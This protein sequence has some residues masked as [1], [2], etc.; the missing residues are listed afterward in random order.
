MTEYNDEGPGTSTISR[1][2][3]LLTLLADA[4]GP[5]TV[6]QVSTDL[7]VPPSTAHRLLNALAGEGFVAASG[8]GIYRIGPRFYRISARVMQSMSQVTIAQPIIDALAAKYN[9]TV[10]LGRYVAADRAMDFIYRADGSQRLTYQIDLHRP[11]SLYW[12]ASGKA[13]LAFLPEN[14]IEQI[15]RQA[16]ASPASGEKPPS[17]RAGMTELR[18]VRERGYAIT[19]GQKLPGAQ[20]V[21]APLFDAKG[22][23]G[24]LCMTF[25]QERMPNASIDAIVTDIMEKSDEISQLLGAAR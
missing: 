21:A 24:C 11:M 13:I 16:G 15:L 2:L 10:L 5:V 19:E 4:P 14:E 12:G 22:V 25:P 9:E 23:F 8:S 3:Y 7:K 20:G 1:A 6:K 17:F 18:E